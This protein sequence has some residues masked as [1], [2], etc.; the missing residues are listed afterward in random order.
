[1]SKESVVTKSVSGAEI[2]DECGKKNAR[3]K[4]LV[5]GGTKY[6]THYTKKYINREKWEKPDLRKV[7]SLIPGTILEVKAV[8]G[9]QV[10]EGDSMM[11]LEAMK[12]QNQLTYPV[13]GVI[14]SVNVVVGQSIPKNY[15]MIEF[16]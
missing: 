11:V 6:K 4:S 8:V 14:K 1:M 16:E 2:V 7:Y 5:I 13:S 3:C 15:L 10:T 12:M 9:A